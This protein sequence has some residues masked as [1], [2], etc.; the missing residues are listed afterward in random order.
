MDS[1]VDALA[2]LEERILRA[3]DLVSALRSERD[4]AV[5][6]AGTALAE[7]QKL[8][9]EVEGLRAERKQ[10]RVRIEKLLGQMDLLSGS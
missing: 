5:A 1:E 3:A 8:R 4:A 2:S 9:Q 7:T 6:A 10:V